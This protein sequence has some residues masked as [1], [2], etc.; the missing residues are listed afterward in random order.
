MT[1]SAPSWI[2]SYASD[3]LQV[4]EETVC[5]AETVNNL[6]VYLDTSL[7]TEKQVNSIS[8][9]CYYH[10]RNIGSIRHYVTRAAC[11]TVAHALTTSRQDN[12]NALLCGLQGTL[13][14]CLQGV[15]N[16]AVRLMTRLPLSTSRNLLFLSANKILDVLVIR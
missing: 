6:T 15:Q 9:A 7:T 8:K 4:G 2:K 12:G 5:V 3:I 13:M 11:K 16:S 14:A 1:G 10:T